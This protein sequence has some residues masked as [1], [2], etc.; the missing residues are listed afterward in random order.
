[1]TARPTS[2]EEAVELFLEQRREPSRRNLAEFAAQ[3]PE[4]EP[5]LRSALEALSALESATADRDDVTPLPKNIG[6]FRVVREIGR[7]GMGVVLEAIEE[8]LGRRVALK[9]LPPEFLP[10]PAARARFRREAE[11]ASRLD[12][13]GIATVFVAGVDDER[14]WIAMRYV[15]GETLS[16]KIARARDEHSSCVRLPQGD[17]RPRAA[18][19]KAASCIARVARALQAAHEQGVVHRDVKPSNIIITPDGSPVL[20]DFG[21]A[22]PQESDGNTLTRT[23]DL[24]G[25]PS[26]FAPELLSGERPRPDAQTDVYALGVT[27]YECLALRRPFDAPTPI[28]LYSAIVSG[29]PTQVRSIHPSVPRDLAVV[30]GMAMERDRSRRYVSA[31]AFAQDVEACVAG[32]PIAARPVPLHGRILRW[33]RREPRQAVLAMLLGFMTLIGAVAAG[34]WAAS[35]NEVLA[36]AD[37]TLHHNLDRAIQ[38]GF[39]DLSIHW[40]PEADIEFKKALAIDPKNAEAFA[41]RALAA[42]KDHRDADVETIL[43]DGPASPAFNALR[44]LAAGRTPPAQHDKEWFAHADSV[45]MFVDGLRLK[46]Q[47]DRAS[48]ADR[49]PLAKLAMQRFEEAVK[50]SPAARVYYQTQRAEAASAAGDEAG[51]RSA[52]AA[53]AVLWPEHNRALFAAGLALENIDPAAAIPLLEKSIRLSPTFEAA[54]QNLG[55]AYNA[56]GDLPSAA[57]ELR[58]AIALNPLDVHA[59]NSLGVVLGAMGC[60]DEALAAFQNALAC[61]PM[62]QTWA[63]IAD[64]EKDTNDVDAAERAFRAALDAEPTQPQVRQ[65]YAQVLMREGRMSEA[66]QEFETVIGLDHRNLESWRRIA[67]LKAKLGLTEESQRAARVGLELAPGDAELMKLCGDSTSADR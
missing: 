50:R 62:W 58:R 5:D 54:H 34:M 22:I 11:L 64:I 7:G 60:Q 9:I 47:S 28:A 27:L 44:D 26:Y 55:N 42:M 37:L 4:L 52:A 51:A 12:H 38:E 31:A 53:L 36:A 40:I 8:P 25:T 29:S 48:D 46:R 17:D 35:R 16:K 39:N 24:A 63:N 15:E 3:Y 66:L 32:L 14:P 19:L 41:G 2:V 21:L 45:E 65:F 33:A 6:A 13:S 10:S 61:R 1:M 67:L 43:A 20:V 57:R 59:H 49:R 18:A 56:V 30:V 23:G